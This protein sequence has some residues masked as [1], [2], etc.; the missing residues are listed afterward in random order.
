MGLFGLTF[1]GSKTRALTPYRELAALISKHTKQKRTRKTWEGA[2]RMY[3]CCLRMTNSRRSSLGMHERRA[4]NAA[5]PT[6][7]CKQTSDNAFFSDKY[8]VLDFVL[9]LSAFASCTEY[10]VF[11]IN[12]NQ[13]QN[14]AINASS[15]SILELPSGGFDSNFLFRVITATAVFRAVRPFRVLT[16][17]PQVQ[18]LL[19]YIPILIHVD[20]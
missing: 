4:L 2:K 1:H 3:C 8:N 12:P 19:E 20:N 16:S 15:N 5:K 7:C 17:V 13:I 11:A 18:K 6:L 9:L 14:S 10:L